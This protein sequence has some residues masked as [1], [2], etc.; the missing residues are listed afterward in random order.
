MKSKLSHKGKTKRE[1]RKVVLDMDNIDHVNLVLVWLVQAERAWAHAMELKGEYD[2]KI[3]GATKKSSSPSKIRNHFLRR[4]RK[5]VS[6]AGQLEELCDV[7]CDR[8]TAAEA[9]AY[10]AWMRGNLHL[11]VEN[12]SAACEDYGTALAI[13]RA[14]GSSDAMTLEAKD[15][16]S[17]RAEHSIDPVLK[18]CQ[19]ELKEG[20]A[21]ESDILELMREQQAFAEEAVTSSLLSAKLEG[22]VGERLKE[23]AHAGSMDIIEWRGK[24]VPVSNESLRVALLKVNEMMIGFDE[25]VQGGSNQNDKKFTALL[26][27]HDEAIDIV[28]TDLQK[29]RGLASGAQ[30]NARKAEQEAL[31]GHVKF[32]K[33][34]CLMKRNEHMVQTLRKADA[35]GSDKEESHLKRTEQI[36]HLYDILLQYARDIAD[37][38]GGEEDDEFDAEARA[39]LLRID[40]LRCYYIGC[41]YAINEKVRVRNFLWHTIL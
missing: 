8:N 21:E 32:F 13:C 4:L 2:L 11:E 31:L 28:E 9:K 33:L 18:Y 6:Y 30:V 29:F 27:A 19:Y 16:F 20:G 14:F 15:L 36:T 7:C 38:P 40:S 5:A 10:A 25:Y 23:A 34:K 24:S 3:A 35:E 22:I 26:S 37:L 17:A 12:W 39:H 41:L 1:F